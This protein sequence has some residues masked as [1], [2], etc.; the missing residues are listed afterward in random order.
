M[1]Y[2]AG[3]FDLCVIGAGHAGIEAALAA[4]RLGR[5]VLCLSMQLDHV[6]NLPCNPSI[7]GS[8]KGHLVREI[9]ALGGEMARAADATCIQFRML[10]RSKGP[11]V[12]SLRAQADRRAYGSFMRRTLELQNNLF[13]KQ[14]EVC[15]V[16]CQDGHIVAVETT[17]GAR[18]TVACVV[19]T[20][21]TYLNA[22]VI[23]GESLRS[24]GPDGLMPALP[25]SDS[26]RALGLPLQRFKTGTPP[27]VS[28]RSVDFSQME[29]QPGEDNCPAFSFATTT[30]VANRAVCHLTWTCEATHELIRRNL[31]RSPL[32]A[33]VIEG[34]G[35]R[36]CPS[37]EDKVMR[38][39]DKKRHPV[40]V[41]PT[42]LDTD[43]LYLQGLSSSLPEEL[44]RE[45]LRTV[46]GLQ[47]AE[48]TRPAYAIE[49]DCLDPLALSPSLETRAVRGLFCAGQ[50]NGTSGY[51]E[52]AAQ[53]LVAGINAAR[54]I[55]GDEPL[56][57][58][59]SSSY[60]GTL[61]DDL[62]TRGTNEPYRMMTSRSEYRLLLRQDNAD[63]RLT[64]IGYAMGLISKERHDATAEKNEQVEREIER[65]SRTVLP[66]HEAL[67]AFL[68]EH[69]SA[70]IVTG[71]RLTD[72]I[73]RPELSYNLLSPFDPERPP[74][75]D[76]VIEQVE[77]SLRYEG[78]L[79]R[80]QAQ[81]DRFSQMENRRL[82]DDIDYLSVHGMQI[83]ARQKLDRIRPATWGQAS[84]VSGV[85]PAD[86][87]AL[88]VFLGKK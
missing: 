75:S 17:L 60:I 18:Y 24:G 44:Q 55:T 46:P 52:A 78:Y 20:A 11:A 57:L 10:G 53:G 6:A 12:H 64:P 58:S 40:F 28:G 48:I 67:L 2:Y 8:A 87:V 49:Y 38:F 63:Q 73:R 54:T 71:I 30:P 15:A 45:I 65:L 43:E 41:E 62:V 36:Y 42:G 22:R 47:N 82:P 33:G 4:A 59:R 14:A 29:I 23:T 39:A 5:R 72:L 81:V 1:S 84:R 68:R 85:N 76:A 26:L 25:L 34:V 51:E 50:I 79:K 61:I 19:L 66:P 35:A 69:N 13:L 80:Q 31:H 83:E 16:H 37:I 9:D 32:Y 3:Y 21:G 56:V 7:G 86:L 88:M 77:I 27:R 70:T 74:L